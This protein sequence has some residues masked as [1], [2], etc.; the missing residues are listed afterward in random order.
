MTQ[1]KVVSITERI[2]RKRR[3]LTHRLRNY[4]LRSALDAELCKDPNY[5]LAAVDEGFSDRSIM[6]D[7][8]AILDRVIAAYR[9]SKQAQAVAPSWCQVGNEWLPI[10]ERQ[11]GSV[12]T[13]LQQ[14]DTAALQA[15]YGDFW[16]HSC[17]AG[18]VGLCFDMQSRFLGAQIS[19]ADR[20]LFLRDTLHRYRLWKTLLGRTHTVRDLDSPIIGNPYGYR[21]EG[22]FVKS[23]ADYLHYYSVAIARLLRDTAGRKVVME[24]GGGYGGMA[25]YLMRDTPNCTYV[26]FDLPEN[27]ALTAYYLLKALP[28]R[29]VLL[30]GEGDLGAS[31][32]EQYD[33]VI[34]PNFEIVRM[35][36]ES[37]D[38]TFNSYSL[39]EMPSEAI[40]RYVAEFTRTTSLYLLH[41]NHTRHSQV[42]A[43]AF[44]IDPQ[45]FDLLYRV[46]A[47]WNYGR[48]PDMD[49]YEFLYRKIQSV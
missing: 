21:L 12:M 40:Q 39:A 26:D 28:E 46:P 49:E 41:I 4:V 44:G 35:P 14:G 8:R 27:M 37:A 7:D 47:L 48:N 32:L 24:L 45:V 30:Y 11:L 31:A 38:L 9:A 18:L 15:I 22:E 5:D 25:Y 23:G 33:V 2:A 36:D 17:S 19:G 29:K 34:M 1:E 16:R 43:D 6:Q 20:R 3:K 10:Y 42:G 13:A